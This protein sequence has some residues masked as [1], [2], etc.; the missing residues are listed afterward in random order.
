[1]DEL[2]AKLAKLDPSARRRVPPFEGLLRVKVSGGVPVQ[3]DL[4]SLH[5]HARGTESPN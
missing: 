4:L 3:S 2:I 1:L 5:V